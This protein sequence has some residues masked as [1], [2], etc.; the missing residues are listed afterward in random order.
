MAL[1]LSVV[2]R[3]LVCLGCFP[4]WR[5]ANVIPILKGPPSSAVASYRPISITLVCLKCLS[6][7]CRFILDDLWNTV[8]CFQ[9]PSFLIENVRVTVMH[10]SACPMHCRVHCRVGRRVGSYKLISAQPLI[11]SAIRKFSISSVLM[12]LKLLCRLYLLSFNQIYH[13]LLLWTVVGVNWL[14]LCMQY[15]CLL[16]YLQQ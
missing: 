14:T 15:A 8:V 9:P 16:N 6:T 5:Q 11:G 4:A 2:F 13:S 10:F 12:V 1:R 3:R 7:W